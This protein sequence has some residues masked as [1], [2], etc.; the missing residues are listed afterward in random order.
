MKMSGDDQ[1]MSVAKSD[2][3]DPE[4]Q[5]QSIT[6]NE[7]KDTNSQIVPAQTREIVEEP[8]KDLVEEPEK[9]LVEVEDEVNQINDETKEES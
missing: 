9:D 1:V 4:E 7:D 5:A 2:Q 8:E 6:T 3:E